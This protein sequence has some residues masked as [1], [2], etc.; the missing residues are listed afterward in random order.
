MKRMR[1][2][3]LMELMIVIGL[4]V[5][6]AALT[7]TIGQRAGRQQ[8][9][10]RLTQEMTQIES[11]VR[12]GWAAE[13]NY[14]TVSTAQVITR[15]YVPAAMVV[16]ANTLRNAWG[17]TWTVAPDTWAGGAA[18]AVTGASFRIT[19]T[20]IP[21]D[22]CVESI[23]RSARHYLGIVVNNGAAT[24]V[25]TNINQAPA[26]GTLTAAC[27]AANGVSIAWITN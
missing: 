19:A 12:D 27:T 7:A 25:V 17:G 10:T 21:T 26:I 5:G 13:A 2:F 3:T 16:D 9:A 14:G 20:N 8:N 24:W 1:G 22:T 4:V 23:Q 15:G 18:E 6:A 11:R